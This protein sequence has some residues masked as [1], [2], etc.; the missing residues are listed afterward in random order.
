MP[1]IVKTVVTKATV[2]QTHSLGQ[3]LFQQGHSPE[4]ILAWLK[5]KQYT[6]RNMRFNAAYVANY[7]AGARYASATTIVAPKAKRAKRA[8]KVAPATEVEADEV[9]PF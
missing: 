2:A 8:S 4:D 6:V 5:S 1:P 9:I 7:V 3:W